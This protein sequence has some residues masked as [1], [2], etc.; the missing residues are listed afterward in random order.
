MRHLPAAR[1]L[2]GGTYAIAAHDG[3]THLAWR[4]AQLDSEWRDE[5]NLTGETNLIITVANP[6]PTAWGEDPQRELFSRDIEVRTPFPPAL[7]ERFADRRFMQLDATTWLD[8]EGA[9]L[10][11]IAVDEPVS[12]LGLEPREAI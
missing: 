4:L 7:Q 1:R 8:H 5:L 11:F 9:E 2:G 10:I 3:H 12:A 6:D